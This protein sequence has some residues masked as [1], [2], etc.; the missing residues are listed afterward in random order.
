FAGPFHLSLTIHEVN[1]YFS[2]SFHTLRDWTETIAKPILH[3]QIRHYQVFLPTLA[4][5]LRQRLPGSTAVFIPSR[6]YSG[7][8]PPGHPLP[9]PFQ[10]IVPGSLDP[11]RRNYNEIIQTLPILECTTPIELVLLGDS[12]TE[13][14]TR[15]IAEFQPALSDR[16]SLRTFN[17]YVSETTYEETLSHAHLIWSPLNVQKSNSRNHPE[18]YGLTTASGLTADLLLTNIPALVPADFIV[19]ESF[20]AAIYPYRSPDEACRLIRHFLDDPAAYAAIRATIHQTFS[21]FA[22]ENF[23]G[24]FMQL[25]GE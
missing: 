11:N 8:R 12:S 4:D 14:G 18:T 16:I 7:H 17:G 3:R 23:V 22:K 5:Q 21:Y 9:T 24:P 10:I 1:E 6:F 13:P 19:P 15:I 25:M 20:R 2:R